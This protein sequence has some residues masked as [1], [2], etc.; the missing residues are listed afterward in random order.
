MTGAKLAHVSAAAAISGRHAAAYAEL[1]LAI[2]GAAALAE[3]RPH[4]AHPAGARIQAMIAG[5]MRIEPLWRRASR[6]TYG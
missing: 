4:A 5:I 1:A 2:D 6:A 3:E